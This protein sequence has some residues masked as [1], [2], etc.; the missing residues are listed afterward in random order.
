MI[1]DIRKCIYCLEEFDIS[2]KPKGFMANHSR[3]CDKNPKRNE[4][5]KHLEEMR[6][7][8]AENGNFAWNKGRTKDTD[9]RISKAS[10]KLK[11][12]YDSGRV[13]K[14][15]K[16][17]THSEETKCII[18]EKA[19]SS[20]HRRLRRKMIDYMMKNGEIVKLDSSWELALA[21]RLDFLN[22]EWNRPE[23]LVYEM[24]GENHKYFPD[25]YLGEFDV[26]LDPKNPYAF[27]V[28]REKI[29]ILNETYGNIIWITTLEECENFSMKKQD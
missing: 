18:S 29:D 4:H 14:F 24:D 25:F 23:P 26:Y 2:N 16:G 1:C 22:I 19:L 5:M 9:E 8:K 6:K 7:V 27:E 15:W 3:W 12:G 10:N 11:E 20:N 17:K 21:K 28:Q 13:K